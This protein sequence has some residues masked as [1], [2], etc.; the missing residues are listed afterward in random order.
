MPELNARTHTQHHPLAGTTRPPSPAS[1]ASPNDNE[2]VVCQL[3][4]REGV[5]LS[6]VRPLPC[7]KK[8]LCLD[9]FW[10]LYSSSFHRCPHCTNGEKPA[11][12]EYKGFE[13]E[14][15]NT[16][17]VL[18]FTTTT[19]PEIDCCN[20][21]M[22]L[23][24]L[25][26]NPSRCGKCNDVEIYLHCARDRKRIAQEFLETQHRVQFANIR[27]E[28]VEQHTAFKKNIQR[29]RDIS[30]E[31]WILHS[32]KTCRL[33]CPSARYIG[34]RTA[35]QQLEDMMAREDDKIRR[36]EFD[37]H[38]DFLKAGKALDRFVQRTEE[39]GEARAYRQRLEEELVKKK[40]SE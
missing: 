17:C 37:S 25:K 23:N 36:L 22:C 1:P 5:A 3:A 20:R 16:K 19:G 8:N 38:E 24:C 28:G 21:L 33:M 27:R 4:P 10:R 30:K 13:K 14:M 26:S 32:T 7:C 39:L 11:D 34:K 9:C 12:K 40:G 15:M 35:V 6:A 31:F 18:C 29:L 2:C